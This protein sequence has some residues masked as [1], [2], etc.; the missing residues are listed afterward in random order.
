MNIILYWKSTKE[1]T[2]NKTINNLSQEII[3]LKSSEMKEIIK[4]IQKG[5]KIKPLSYISLFHKSD[6]LK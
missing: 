1:K 6:D 2:I 3:I 4:P 5:K